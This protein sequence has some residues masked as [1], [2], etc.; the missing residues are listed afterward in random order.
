MKPRTRERFYLALAYLYVGLIL[1]ALLV[2]GF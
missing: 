1:F 2:G